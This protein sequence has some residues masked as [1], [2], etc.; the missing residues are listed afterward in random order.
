MNEH[1]EHVRRYEV[2]RVDPIYSV[3]Y[4]R[5]LARLERADHQL[6]IASVLTQTYLRSKRE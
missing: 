5:S 2:A 4:E 6:A 1:Y 3:N